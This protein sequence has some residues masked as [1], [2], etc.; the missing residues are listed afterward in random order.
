METVTYS[1]KEIAVFNGVLALIDQGED[2][3]TIK[4][5]EIARAAGIGKGTLYIYFDSREEII[6][7]A[8]LYYLGLQLQEVLRRVERAQDFQ[9]KCFAALDFL[10]ECVPKSHVMLHFLL[11]YAYD[12]ALSSLAENLIMIMRYEKKLLTDGLIDLLRQG[13]AEGLFP[14][15]ADEE[16][17]IQLFVS[18][19]LGFYKT[20]WSEKLLSETQ[21]EALKKN[22]YH[23]ILKS[24]Q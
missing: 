22:A 17:V 10:E 21:V 2:L 5:S 4:V 14:M 6:I 13:S 19:V 15:P 20:F 8:I 24:L 7:K 12:P 18:V 23:I 3:Y 11:F 9:G 16:Y 1:D